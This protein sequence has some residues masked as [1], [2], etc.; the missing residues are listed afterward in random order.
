M[1][2]R[3]WLGC[4]SAGTQLLWLN[5]FRQIV[6]VDISRTAWD[7]FVERYGEVRLPAGVSFTQANDDAYLESRG[8]D[9]EPFDDAAGADHALSPCEFQALE[10]SA[11]TASEALQ[12]VDVLFA[13]STCFDD[14]TLADTLACGLRPGARV[15]TVDSMLPNSGDPA[16]ANRPRFRLVQRAFVCDHSA[17]VWELSEDLPTFWIDYAVLT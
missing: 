1:L 2:L 7:E 13:F 17:Y 8:A 5:G 16:A 11:A 14:V 10:V 9:A 3:L 4:G 12:A 15:V 6:A